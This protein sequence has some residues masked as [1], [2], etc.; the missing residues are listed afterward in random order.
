MDTLTFYPPSCPTDSNIS[1]NYPSVTFTYML[2]AIVAVTFAIIIAVNYNSVVVLNRKIRS[3]NISNT[4]WIIYFAIVFIR[5][6]ISSVRFGVDPSLTPASDLD[7]TTLCLHG[8]SAFVLA[9]ALNHQRRWRSPD[10]PQTIQQVFLAPR[11]NEALVKQQ[12]A[13]NSKRIL[14]EYVTKHIGIPEV[15]CFVL[16]LLYGGAVAYRQINL[17]TANE[18]TGYYVLMGVWALVEAPAVLLTA[19]IVFQKS[20]SDGP[21]LKSKLLLVVGEL[22]NFA[23]DLP[24]PLWT[25]LL[26]RADAK[27][28]CVFVIASWVDL[29]HLLYI[30]SLICFFFFVRFEYLR[31]MEECILTTLSQIQDTFAYRGF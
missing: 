28:E 30:G 10:S 1:V 4:F 22:L 13:H 20:A 29:V 16:L 21:S 15:L 14:P 25:E 11:E 17:S 9:L 6:T 31:N 18:A 24:L 8:V 26:A 3:Q 27:D 2:I 12:G 23:N 5:T 7:L 19:I